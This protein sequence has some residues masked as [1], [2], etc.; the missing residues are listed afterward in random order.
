MAFD[1][2]CISRSRARCTKPHQKILLLAEVMNFLNLAY[3][4]IIILQIAISQNNFSNIFE[5]TIQA[6]GLKLGSI[7][8][9]MSFYK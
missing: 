5:K 8:P 1:M 3:N 2:F 4:T 6:R 9:L 7:V